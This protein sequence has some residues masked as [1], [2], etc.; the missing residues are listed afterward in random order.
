MKRAVFL[1]ACA[2]GSVPAFADADGAKLYGANCGICHQA[3]AVGVPG[4]F[5]PLKGRVDKIASTP[6]GK[7]YLADVLNGGLHG[8][9]KAG[10]GT[11]VGFMPAF[12]TLPEDQVAAI[13]T[14]VASLGDTKPAPVFTADEIKGA[15]AA[16][17][18]ASA[19]MAERKALDAAHKLP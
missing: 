6:E 11:Y 9:I 4:Q 17:K 15:R 7:A 2:F 8:M 14:Y 13:L 1:L 12:K 18:P 3:G 19:V 16:P 10:G 5:P